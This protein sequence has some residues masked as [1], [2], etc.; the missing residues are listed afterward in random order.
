MVI[1]EILYLHNLNLQE[2]C[3]LVWQN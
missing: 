2:N 3:R 1:K